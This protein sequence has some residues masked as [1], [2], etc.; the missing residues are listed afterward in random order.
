[1]REQVRD[2]GRLEHIIEAIDN[3]FEFVDGVTFDEYCSNKMMRFA[4]TRSLEIVGEASYMLTKEFKAQHPEVD[5]I[6]IINMRHIL[7]HGY[8]HIEDDIVWATVKN[9]LPQLKEQIIRIMDNNIKN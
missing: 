4:V 3:A 2:S 7:V 8:F 1:M 9:R 6:K 5:W